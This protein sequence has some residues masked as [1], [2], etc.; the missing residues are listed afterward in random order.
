MGPG[1]AS[2]TPPVSLEVILTAVAVILAVVAIILL[3]VFI[4]KRKR[5]REEEEKPLR[6]EVSKNEDI[7]AQLKEEYGVSDDEDSGDD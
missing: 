2:E 1:A 6:P 3:I 5:S 4:G 7:I